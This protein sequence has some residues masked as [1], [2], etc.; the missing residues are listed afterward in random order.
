MVIFVPER[1]T[2]PS[3][4]PPILPNGSKIAIAIT[5]PIASAAPTGIAI[6]NRRTMREWRRA[7]L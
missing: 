5:V 2:G 6:R 1:V 3:E 7:C 4:R